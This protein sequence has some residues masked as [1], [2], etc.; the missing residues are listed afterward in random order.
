MKKILI[1]LPIIILLLV[2]VFWKFDVGFFTGKSKLQEMS[3][4]DDDGDTSIWQSRKYSPYEILNYGWIGDAFDISS[5]QS[6]TVVHSSETYGVDSSDIITMDVVYEMVGLDNIQVEGE[7]NAFSVAV[8]DTGAYPHRDL[9]YPKD[10]IIAFVDMVNNLDVP[11]DDNGHGTAVTGIIAGNS[12]IPKYRGLAPFV[13]IVSVKVLD[14]QCKGYKRDIIEGVKWVIANREKYNI[15]LMNLSVGIPTDEYDELSQL[16]DEAYSQGI[17]V[18]TSVGN[19][20]NG[21]SET[22]Y[23]PAISDSVVS[24][25]SIEETALDNSLNYHLA[26]FSSTW[27][28]DNENHKPEVV[29][30]GKNIMTLKSDIYYKGTGVVLEEALYACDSG[31][32]LSAAVVTAFVANFIYKYPDKTIDEIKEILYQNCIELEEAESQKCIYAHKNKD[33]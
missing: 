3:F 31:T 7:D 10:K 32:S 25:G 27:I 24:V 5:W 13:D 9:V 4:A 29:A 17:F 14:Y 20:T 30:P 21:S 11:Y 12:K 18:V 15:K 33:E 23:T 16:V 19:K 6:G 22:K 1:A 28:S 2:F 8:L 26:E